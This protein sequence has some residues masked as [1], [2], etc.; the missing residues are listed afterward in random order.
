MKVFLGALSLRESTKL[1]EEVPKC[2]MTLVPVEKKIFQTTC[3]I[4]SRIACSFGAF[5]DNYCLCEY[6]GFN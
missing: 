1:T 3:N 2:T 6:D 5:I 4:V